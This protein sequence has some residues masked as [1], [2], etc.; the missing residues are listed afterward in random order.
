M[1]IGEDTW[2]LKSFRLD[3]LGLLF[4]EAF[5]SSGDLTFTMLMIFLAEEEVK[6]LVM[7]RY[8]MKHFWQRAPIN[9]ID[10]V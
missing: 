8:S 5:V 2:V 9:T 4:S 3:L 7:L 6:G 1:S 10:C